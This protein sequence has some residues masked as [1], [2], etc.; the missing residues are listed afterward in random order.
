MKPINQLIRVGHLLI[1]LH[2]LG[3]AD[4]KVALLDAECL[5]SP[6]RG[7]DALLALLAL[8]GGKDAPISCR[9]SVRTRR[10]L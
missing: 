3:S 4:E 1:R 10:R 5:A 8:L 6:E 9:I 2:R 7:D